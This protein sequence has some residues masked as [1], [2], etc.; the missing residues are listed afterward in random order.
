MLVDDS[1]VVGTECLVYGG[2]FLVPAAQLW[3]RVVSAAL[4]GMP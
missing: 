1:E 4:C 3:L 2:L